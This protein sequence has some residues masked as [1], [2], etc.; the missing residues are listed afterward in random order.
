MS[1]L[2]LLE[3]RRQLLLEEIAAINL[4]ADSIRSENSMSIDDESKPIRMLTIRQAA[5]ETGVSYDWIRKMCIQGKIKHVRIGTKRLINS[6]SLRQ[7]LRG[8]D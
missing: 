8:D 5:D 1:E 2:E 4:R 7:Y 6:E 3:K